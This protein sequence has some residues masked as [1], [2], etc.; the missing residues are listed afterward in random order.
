L[1]RN[2][3][4]QE[5]RRAIPF[6]LPGFL[7]TCIL[8][9]YPLFNIIYLSFVSDDLSN[10]KFVGL[11]NYFD[12]NRVPQFFQ[13]TR[14]TAIWAITTVV[15]SFAL[16]LIAALLIEQNDIKFKGTWRSILMT[17]WITP[18]VVKAVAWNWLYSQDY[19][20][21]NH[22]LISIGIIKD[23]I[24]WL[25]SSNFSLLA[26]IIVQ[27]WACFPFAML[28]LSAGIQAIPKDIYEACELEGASVFKRTFYITIPLLKDVA[29]I[30]FLIIFMGSINEFA[31]MW[32]IT[33]GGPAGSSTTLSMLIYDQFMSMNLNGASASA[34]LQLVFSMI[35][36]VLYVMSV[37]KED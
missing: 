20:M 10:K 24:P 26:V 28:M 32:I 11:K 1:F 37:G 2:Y 22:I 23:P 6:V 34:V 19:G 27:I 8:I 14:N 30:T 31:L 18:V 3:L 36:A 9:L 17:S 35:F 33:H 12:L 13:A 29:F 4:T 15:F 7:V 25:I 16:G 5:E 21:L